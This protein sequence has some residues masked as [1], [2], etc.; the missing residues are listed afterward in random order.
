MKETTELGNR[1]S[2]VTHFGQENWYSSNNKSID[3]VQDSTHI[4]TKLRNRLLKASIYLPLGEFIVSKS[5]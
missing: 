1:H 5:L 3:A 2:N 4:G